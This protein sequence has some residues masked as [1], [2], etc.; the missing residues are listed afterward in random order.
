MDSRGS[1]YSFEHEKYTTKDK[2][3]LKPSPFIIFSNISNGVPW[4]WRH[5]S[6]EHASNIS[7]I[8]PIDLLIE[9]IMNIDPLNCTE[10]EAKVNKTITYSENLYEMM[11]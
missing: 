8:H 1:R 6:K 11:R 2:K 9:L 3:L 10:R 4:A 5:I 7:K